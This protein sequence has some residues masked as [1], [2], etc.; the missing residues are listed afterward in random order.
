MDGAQQ[1]NVFEQYQDQQL[2]QRYAPGGAQV[3][4]VATG[5]QSGAQSFGTIY[6][7]QLG[8]KA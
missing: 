7:A 6:A 2:M 1:P 8:R 5:L 3:N 4:P